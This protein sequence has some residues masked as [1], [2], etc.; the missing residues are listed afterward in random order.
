MIEIKQ[1]KGRGH[2]DRYQLFI[3]GTLMKGAS[4][5]AYGETGAV[6]GLTITEH[7]TFEKL[8]SYRFSELSELSELEYLELK[9]KFD[10]ADV[11]NHIWISTPYETPTS[12]PP[13]L[14]YRS[15]SH[16]RYTI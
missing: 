12:K 15:L 14:E 5:A 10:W 8:G 3:N 9:L 7:A 11:L 16:I 13:L 6:Y 4:I 2:R 1:K